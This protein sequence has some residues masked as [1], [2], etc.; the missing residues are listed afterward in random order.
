MLKA[1]FSRFLL[2]LLLFLGLLSCNS[3]H[4]LN[5]AERIFKHNY[6]LWLKQNVE[7]YS[8]TFQRR[9]FCIL[10]VTKPAHIV[11]EK[12]KKVQANYIQSGEPVPEEYLE[13][14][15]SIK[16]AFKLISEAIEQ[17]AESIKVNYNS[18]HGFPTEVNI[19]YNSE[20]VD[21]EIYLS[22]SNFNEDCHLDSCKPPISTGCKPYGFDSEEYKNYVNT[23]EFFIFESFPIQVDAC[24]RSTHKDTCVEFINIT[25]SIEAS[26]FTIILKAE[27]RIPPDVGCG[28][29]LTPYARFI[30][31]NTS[32]LKTGRYTL[33]FLGTMNQTAS[34]NFDYQAGEL[35]F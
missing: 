16:E 34:A 17:K 31:V 27:D 25:Q 5:E 1:I 2:I 24:L 19:D 30:R 9:C 18:Q 6:D 29:A 33:R 21:E 3:T 8:I 20:I 28:D 4:K 26:T 7:S 22:I 12:D 23:I 14:F 13:S 10:D 32:G 35:T 11:V 15:L